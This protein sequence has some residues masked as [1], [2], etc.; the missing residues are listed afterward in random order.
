M[1]FKYKILVLWTLFLLCMFLTL[2]SLRNAINF[3]SIEEVNFQEEGKVNYLVYLKENDYF[4]ETYLTEGKQ[5]IASLVDYVDANFTYSFNGYK[6]NDYK[7]EYSIIA[8]LIA[9]QKDKPDEILYEKDFIL[10]DKQQVEDINPFVINENIKIDYDYYNSI[11]NE[12]KSTYALSIDS[13]LKVQLNIYWSAKDKI[14]DKDVGKTNHLDLVIPLS[15]QTIKVTMNTNDINQNV[16]VQSDPSI[17]LTNK[18]FFVS[19]WLFIFADLWLGL[20][21]VNTYVLEKKRKGEYLLK[22]EKI[23]KQYDRAIVETNIL[24]KKAKNIIDV[25]SFEELLDARENVEKPI[26]HKKETDG[27][28]FVIIDDDIMY[29]YILKK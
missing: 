15:Q 11:I 16:S 28:I 27:S 22:L 24:P 4:S 10:K 6:E 9:N 14:F 23:E 19:F 12:F 17:K 5:Y 1:R 7:Y 26:L 18:V 29:R 25:N 3:W 20:L 13:Y 21:I 8:T 2:F